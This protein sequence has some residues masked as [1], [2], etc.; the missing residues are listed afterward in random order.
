MISAKEAGAKIRPFQCRRVAKRGPTPPHPAKNPLARNTE[1][2]VH[3]TVYGAQA[4]PDPTPDQT[5]SRP[6]FPG[7]LKPMN[8]TRPRRPATRA[9]FEIAVFCALT[10]EAEA[11]LALFDTRW[12][13]D[14][15]CTYDKAA[16]DPNAYSTGAVG[17]HNVVL[18]HMPG[19]GKVNATAVATNCRTSFPNIKLALIVGVCGVVPFY[20]GGNKTVE[21]VLGDV[22][23]GNGVVQYD[24]GRRFP[25]QFV[26]KNTL[27]DA[28]GRPN[29]EILSLLAKLKGFDEQTTL[30]GRIS[31]YM[32]VLRGKPGL[33]AAYPG[34]AHDRLFEAT[35]CHA[36]D[37]MSCEESACDDGKLLRRARLEHGGG[38]PAVHFGLVASGDTVM[39]SGEDRD[40]VARKAGVIGFEMEGAGVW[41]IF[42]CVV[43][44]GACDYADC[45]KTKAWQRYAAATAA[46]CMNAFLGYWVPSTTGT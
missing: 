14:R 13:N 6:A 30:Q 39:K 10:I 25:G 31:E 17:R 23:I 21:I 46:A 9:D 38:Q 27:L 18:V 42:P 41:D 4:D 33:A 1:C 35:Y 36:T 5:E 32:D 20:T 7:P 43:I 2:S 12:D 22:I 11:V 28:L 45:H 37:G 26:P 40:D 15:R 8:P 24:L 44:K 16:G 3:S 34:A 19:M 29:T